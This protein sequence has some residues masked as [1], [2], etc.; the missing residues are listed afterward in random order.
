MVVVV[1]ETEKLAPLAEVPIGAPPEAAVYHPIRLPAEVAFRFELCPV[2][3]DEG[4]AVTEVGAGRAGE[5]VMTTSSKLSAHAPLASVHL[6]VLAPVPNPLTVAVGLV[7][8]EK[9]PDPETTVHAPFPVVGAFADNVTEVPQRLWSLPALAVVKLSTTMAL[10][11]PPLLEGHG[12]EVPIILT[13]YVVLV[14]GDA[15]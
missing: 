12:D 8:G 13:Q 10:V 6:N 9:L 1:G 3:I 14:V 11:T 7:V 4:V 2:T 5:E 15:S